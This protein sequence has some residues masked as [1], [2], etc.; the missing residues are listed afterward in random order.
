MIHQTLIHDCTYTPSE[1]PPPLKSIAYGV[2]YRI[3]FVDEHSKPSCVLQPDCVYNLV[4]SGINLE[5]MELWESNM[6]F[7]V[8]GYCLS[9]KVSR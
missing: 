7:T 8:F 6:C 5:K 3:L 4:A 2:S 1:T 9:S